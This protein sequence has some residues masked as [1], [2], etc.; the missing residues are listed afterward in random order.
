MFVH[1]PTSS[2]IIIVVIKNFTDCQYLLGCREARA[3]AHPR[4]PIVNMHCTTFALNYI[5]FHCITKL[6][7]TAIKCNQYTPIVNMHC[8]TFALSYNALHY[9]YNLLQLYSAALH[10]TP[11][12]TKLLFCW[13]KAEHFDTGTAGGAGDKF[14]VCPEYALALCIM[15]YALHWTKIHCSITLWWNAICTMHTIAPFCVFYLSLNCT[16]THYTVVKWNR[17]YALATQTWSISLLLIIFISELLK[18]FVTILLP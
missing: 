18:L 2:I 13:Q 8:T 15:H 16:K 9:I 5:A 7:S 1:N 4:A 10:F 6:V 3:T 17:E 12:H 14:Q 11:K